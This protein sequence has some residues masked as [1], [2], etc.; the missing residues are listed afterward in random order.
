MSNEL[1]VTEGYYPA[2][3]EDGKFFKLSDTYVETLGY[4]VTGDG[5][6][7]VLSYI[8]NS[9]PL[10]AGDIEIGAVELKDADAD[11][12]AN[13]VAGAINGLGVYSVGG[14]Q[15]I[16]DGVDYSIK[17]T[18]TSLP[19]SKSINA[20]IVDGNGDQIT[21]FGTALSAETGTPVPV[22]NGEPVNLWIDE[23]GR[24]VI[25]GA[26]TNLDALDVH[27]IND[28]VVLRMAPVTSLDDAVSA[29]IGGTVDVSM[30]HN[31]TIHTTSTNVVSGATVTV[32]HSIDNVN[33]V[34][35]D[36]NNITKNLTTELT[37]TNKAYMYIR[38]LVDNVL[39]GTYRTVIIAG[40]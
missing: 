17:A 32:Q 25:F 28:A 38:T 16:A 3:A 13:I 19:N 31:I 26:N 2:I 20:M 18:V 29:T 33:W 7:A 11:I 39:D 23:Y 15:A 35:L 37:F 6:Y 34:N 1:N 14:A 40:N 12:R 9:V 36:V 30:Y 10:S 22:G 21:Y 8:I 5:K 27:V 4:P 24:Q